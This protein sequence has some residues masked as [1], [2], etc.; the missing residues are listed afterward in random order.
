MSW[1]EGE[2]K[3]MVPGTKGSQLAQTRT[4]RLPSQSQGVTT[5]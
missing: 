5:I 1:S 2:M 4:E 3:K